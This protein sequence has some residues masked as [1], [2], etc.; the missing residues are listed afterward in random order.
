MEANALQ[1]SHTIVLQDN[2][3]YVLTQD[4]TPGDEDNAVED[5]LDIAD[6][7]TIVGN[8]AVVLNNTNC[9]TDNTTSAGEFRLFH[10]LSGGALKV[11][12]LTIRGGCDDVD[13]PSD[14]GMG[15]GIYVQGDLILD[16][17]VLD[18]NSATDFGGAIEV[19]T[20]GSVRIEDSRI[21]SNYSDY[22][23]GIDV[24]EGSVEIVNTTISSN[25]ATGDGGGV[26]N[27]GGNVTITG[28]TISSNVA[29]GRGGGVDIDNTSSLLPNSLTM[30]NSTVANN[31]AAGPSGGG[32][33][34]FSGTLNLVFSTVYQNEPDGIYI[35]SGQTVSIK[36]SILADN[37]VNNSV[38]NCAGPGSIVASGMN[39]EG[40]NSNGECVTAANNTNFQNNPNL[41]L[42]G[43][44]PFGGPTETVALGPGSVAIDAATDCT[45][46]NGAN[47]TTDQR[48]ITR[49][50]SSNCDVG[51][52]EYVDN[53]TTQRYILT[54]E[55]QGGGTV[56]DNNNT[57]TCPGDCSEAF[58]NSTQV[59]LTA[60]P[61]T[62]YNFSYWSG[63]CSGCGGNTSCTVQMDSD[64]TCTA[65]FTLQVNNHAPV[66]DGFTATPTTGQAPLRVSF[67]CTAHDPDG[68]VVEYQFDFDG[69]G[70][71]DEQH[72][73][74]GQ[75]THTYSS[76]GT[77]NAYCIAIDNASQKGF[78]EVLKITVSSQ[79][80]DNGGGGGGGGCFIATAA[81]GSY[82]EPHVKVLRDFR[83]RYLLRN[84]PG[85]WLVRMYYRYSPPLARFISR[86]KSL[87]FVT[88]LVLTPLVYGVKYPGLTGGGI[89]VFLGL[90]LGLKRRRQR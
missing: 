89:L 66:I 5:D 40:E 19:D 42:R 16:G 61:D 51:A 58:D 18:N 65:T 24:T 47:V 81:Y 64:R 53:T 63:D 33:D 52:F 56:S 11:T 54:I 77:Y 2:A 57:I 9:V 86:H 71:A 20:Q 68:Q 4:T 31:I 32:I 46:L 70:S 28:S 43:P 79:G 90:V 84:A 69:D 80:G 76:S 17:V 1:G 85:R 26:F 22:G 6:N 23:A 62:G 82:L 75:T 38:L 15:G 59:N 21:T 50:Q 37:G 88:R 7:I 55:V 36:N 72:N 44:G 83:D 8:N 35:S 41:N 14:Y 12:N 60:Q 27:D 13:G 39:Y 10:V 87:K 78:S 48:G 49:P 3:T 45:D 73:R 67:T 74:T 30:L 29:S 34:L 25:H